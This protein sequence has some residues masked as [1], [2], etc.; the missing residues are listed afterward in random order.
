MGV[1]TDSVPILSDEDKAE[2]TLDRLN[3]ELLEDYFRRVSY[4]PPMQ[5]DHIGFQATAVEGWLGA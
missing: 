5:I 3:Y 1:K 4:E 2:D